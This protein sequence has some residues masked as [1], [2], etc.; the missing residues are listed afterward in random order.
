MLKTYEEQLDSDMEWALSEGSLH[1]DQKSVVHSALREITQR[2]D[3]LQIPYAVVGG[4]ALFLHG[5]KRFTDDVD[6]LVT[7]AGLKAIHERLI[8]LG[9]VPLFEGSK[10][11][12]DAARGVRI[13]FLVTGGFPGDGKPKPV[14]F[15]DP[16]D[17]F[18]DRNGIHCLSLEKLIDLKLASALSNPGRVRDFG[19]VQDLIR[20]L[21]LEAEFAERL[22][23][24]V[25]EKFIELWRGVKDD[26]ASE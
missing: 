14:V 23:P 3:A 2:L 5:Y 11:L 4:M 25:R 19:D 6:L 12:R 7:P 17:T 10:N 15:P 16:A 26:R 8:G 24:S 13:E 21:G 20:I 22:D 9:Y 18:V 1:F